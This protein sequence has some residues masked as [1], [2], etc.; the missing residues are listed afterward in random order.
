MSNPKKKIEQKI[1]V[2]LEMDDSLTKIN[3]KINKFV[4]IN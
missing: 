2:T 1:N 3:I 4:Q